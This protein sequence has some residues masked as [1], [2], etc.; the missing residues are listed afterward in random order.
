MHTHT[1]ARTHKHT[2]TQKHTHTCALVHTASHGHALWIPWTC[3]ISWLLV[4]SWLH[5]KGCEFV[6]TQWI[7]EGPLPTTQLSQRFK[8]ERTPHGST[9]NGGPAH[10]RVSTQHPPL[11]TALSCDPM[12]GSKLNHLSVFHWPCFCVQWLV[13]AWMSGQAGQGW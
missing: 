12:P 4:F 10:G 5:G 13:N 9:L 2:R 1:R 3:S 7:Q 8:Y 6:Y 11:Q